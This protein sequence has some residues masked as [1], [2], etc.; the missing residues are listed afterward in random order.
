MDQPGASDA[1]R[2]R[3]L[4]TAWVSSQRFANDFSSELGR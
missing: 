3:G 4:K 2:D 1:E